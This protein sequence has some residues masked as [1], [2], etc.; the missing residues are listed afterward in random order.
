MWT[1]RAIIDWLA[2]LGVGDG[3]TVDLVMSPGPYVPVMPDNV[4]VVTTVPGPGLFLEGAADTSGF[5]LLIRGVQ[6]PTS[7]DA[8]AEENALR[9]DRLILTADLPAEVA[10]G[11][12]LLPLSRSGGRPAPLAQEDD[13]DRITFVCTYLTP[14]LEEASS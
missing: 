2:T 8:S 3:L 1:T 10:T 6:D 9:A 4:G 11:V 5:Q 12:R 13:G 14:V 7:K